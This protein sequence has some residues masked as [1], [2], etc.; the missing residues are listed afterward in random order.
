MVHA[1]ALRLA[2]QS[3]DG[4]KLGGE[5]EADETYIGG[6]A[7]FMHADKRERLNIKQGRSIAGKVAVMGLLERDRRGIAASVPKCCRA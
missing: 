2:L 3:K 4:G 5:V 6:K 7:R 1:V